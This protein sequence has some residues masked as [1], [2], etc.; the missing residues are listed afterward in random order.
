MHT[1]STNVANKSDT[2]EE[3]VCITY[4]EG[5]AF[6]FDKTTDLQ[7][8]DDKTIVC[9]VPPLNSQMYYVI[10]PRYYDAYFGGN[11]ILKK[12]Y[13]KKIL[14]TK[15]EKWRKQDKVLNLS[16]EEYEEFGKKYRQ[17]KNLSQK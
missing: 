6:E 13:S 8:G 7:K 9:E 12:H 16:A 3:E 15:F 10:L 2:T 11:S 14:K 4:I 17:R 1:S 5:T